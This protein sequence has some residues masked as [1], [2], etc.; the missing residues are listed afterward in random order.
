MEI[1]ELTL[2]CILFGFLIV[3][4]YSGGIEKLGSS[5]LIFGPAGFLVGAGLASTEAIQ[6]SRG[7]A[8]LRWPTVDGVVMMSDY[9]TRWHHGPHEEGKISYRYAV[10]GSNYVAR[11]VKISDGE[12]FTEGNSAGYIREHP[13]GTTVVVSFEK[14]HPQMAVLQPGPDFTN[15]GFGLLGLG[16]AGAG[17]ALLLCGLRKGAGRISKRSEVPLDKV[18]KG[19]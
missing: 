7:Y 16:S 2:V 4:L 8:S 1:L 18:V 5:L 10:N 15:L 3:F 13:V 14:Q 17:I 11:R 6:L 12:G 9:R 19:D